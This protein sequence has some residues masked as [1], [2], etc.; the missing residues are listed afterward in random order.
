[1]KITRQ[2]EYKT[3]YGMFGALLTTVC[4]MVAAA[5]LCIIAATD[6]H[7]QNLRDKYSEAHPLKVSCDSEFYPYEFMNENGDP[8]GINI[9]IIA[10]ALN[11]FGIKFEFVMRDKES[12]NKDFE[13]METNL[14]LT[15]I[16]EKIPGVYYGK[17]EVATYRVVLAQRKAARQLKSLHELQSKDKVV[18]KSGGYPLEKAMSAGMLKPEQ[19]QYKSVKLALEGMAN[20]EIDYFIGGEKTVEHIITRY[21]LGEQI[22]VT[23]IDVPAG[24]MYFMSRDRQLIEALDD[25][26]NRMEQNGTL[27][28]LNERWEER[29]Q[30]TSNMPT[31]GLFIC[32]GLL[33]T[34]CVFLLID[35]IVKNRLKKTLR[36]I[37]D[38]NNIVRTALEMGGNYI[39]CSNIKTQKVRNLYGNLVKGQEMDMREF[40]A[41]TH[42]EDLQ[43][44]RDSYAN[45]TKTEGIFEPV[46]YRLNRGTAQNPDWH[47][48]MGQMAAE[49]SPRGEL[50]NVFTTLSDVTE[51]ERQERM[52]HDTSET[53]KHIF[54]MSIT[55]IALY[56]SD[57]KLI[58][59]NKMMRKIFDSGKF[60]M[61]TIDDTSFFDLPAVR[62][63]YARNE[64]KNFYVCTRCDLNDSGSI[65]Y[66]DF[67][68]RPVKDDQGNLRYYMITA[69][70]MK[71]ERL[72]YK[73]S[74]LQDEQIRKA[75]I[76]T[77]KYE[78]EL[79]ILLEESN[80]MVWKS[81]LAKKSFTI[82]KD[83]RTFEKRTSFD[84]FI[85]LVSNE[86]QQEEV[87]RLIDPTLSGCQTITTTIQLKKTLK[88][89]DRKTWYAMNS[90]PEY[91]NNGNIKG[92]FGLIRDI[93]ELIKVQTK[94]KEET[95]RANDSVRLK[96]AFL[97]NMTHEIRTP[98]NAIVG[99]CDVLQSIDAPEE[100]TE[101]IKIILNNCDL[102][103]QLIN[104]ILIIS[105]LDSNGLVLRPAKVDFADSFNMICMSLRQRVQEP[106]VEFIADNPYD[107]LEVVMDITRIQQVIT[108]FL[109]NA[110]KYTHSGHIKLGYRCQDEGLYIYCEDTGTGIPADKCDKI[111][112][113]FVKL[114][115]YIQGAGL[116]LSICKAIAE[117]CG[118]RIG[119]DSEEG[120]GSTFWIWIPIKKIP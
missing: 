79:K 54:E 75:N 109:T 92:C 73:Q 28:K 42:T 52:E 70:D 19:V 107:K 83:L 89:D 90:V 102:L 43:S 57:G 78:S 95:E 3:K 48:F 88:G 2:M 33:T 120:K 44:I 114:N 39:I 104:D 85:N 106:G 27:H 45:L 119:V 115:D 6:M 118:G 50:L 11:D 116:G 110:V 113:R 65:D 12:A 93:D 38:T 82:Y 13:A 84:D 24:R 35:R 40:F 58:S 60:S 46:K 87:R 53:Y 94:M 29:E 64:E 32:F 4:R 63:F 1:M 16:V 62:G 77:Q 111:F 47:V 37:L 26:L 15:P 72:M 34:T 5:A 80:M 10:S 31:I 98:L 41:M 71:D 55:G 14:M 21:N 25:K 101:F 91:D 51:E 7:A 67:R 18:G 76:E 81:N 100:R 61:S 103:M 74:R 68:C 69:R 97:A 105:E 66:I 86:E 96:S 8:A 17:Y 9:D 30:K 36:S 112:G 56:S 49:T 99:F 20:N 59:A 108:N 23:P 117:K 22:A